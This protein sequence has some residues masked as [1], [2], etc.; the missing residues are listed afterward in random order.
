M[1]K[2]APILIGLAAGKVLMAV[3]HGKP[4]GPGARCHGGRRGFG[5]P[6]GM[7][8]GHGP[9]WARHSGGCPSSGE[10]RAQEGEYV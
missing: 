3:A 8:K 6:P 2:M 4:G 7:R 10:G 9:P 5:P 1:R